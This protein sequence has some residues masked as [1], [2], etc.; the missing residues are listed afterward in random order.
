MLRRLVRPRSRSGHLGEKSLALPGFELRDVHP[1][2]HV[3]VYRVRSMATAKYTNTTVREHHT[4]KSC[5]EGQEIVAKKQK[6]LNDDR[7][8]AY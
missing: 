7:R 3:A 1:R 5:C 8:K 6:P 4:L 2:S